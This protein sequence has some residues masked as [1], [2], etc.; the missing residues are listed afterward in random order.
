MFRG[1]RQYMD[2]VANDVKKRATAEERLLLQDDPA[3][4]LC[5]LNKHITDTKEHVR[6]V[7]EQLTLITQYL[8]STSGLDRELVVKKVE[9]EE[10]LIKQQR[11]LSAA[12][13]RRAEVSELLAD[14]GKSQ[15]R[16]ASQCAVEW[17]NP[18]PRRGAQKQHRAP[19][20]MKVHA[21]F[22]ETLKNNPGQWALFK[23][24]ASPNFATRL[25]DAYPGVEATCRR[26]ACSDG[27]QRYDIYARW[28]GGF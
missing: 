22:V 6:K 1:H 5:G 10:K 12:R 17:A 23:K 19:K 7:T 11:F 28:I 18:A 20:P 14:F 26:I 13:E 2:T 3:S 9:L 27:K 8:N 25:K 21:E 15:S 4:W 24:A 16:G